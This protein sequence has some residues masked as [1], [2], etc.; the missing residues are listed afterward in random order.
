MG[1]GFECSMNHPAHHGPRGPQSLPFPLPL[2]ADTKTPRLTP[3]EGLVSPSPSESLHDASCFWVSR[4]PVSE[5]SL[6]AP[7]TCLG[8]ASPPLTPAWVHMGPADFTGPRRSPREDSVLP[9]VPRPVNATPPRPQ[10]KDHGAPLVP[11]FLSPQNPSQQPLNARAACSS[12]PLPNRSR[13]TRAVSLCW[14][15]PRAP[16]PSNGTNS[17]YFLAALTHTNLADLWGGVGGTLLTTDPCRTPG[18]PSG[19]SSS[20]HP[21]PRPRPVCGFR[22]HPL[23]VGSKW[24]LLLPGP[25][26]ELQPR[27]STR[28]VCLGD[29]QVQHLQNQTPFPASESTPTPI[30]PAPTLSPQVITPGH[31]VQ[32]WQLFP[33]HPW[34]LLQ[35]ILSALPLM[36]ILTRLLGPPLPAM[37]RPPWARV[38]AAAS[39]SAPAPPSP[40]RRLPPSSQQEP[41]KA[42][43]VPSPSSPPRG[44]AGEVAESGPTTSLS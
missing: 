37:S 25:L 6:A 14:E 44:A 7:H 16:Q 22:N 4:M 8:P 17:T 30:P 23:S 32:P 31:W 27:K 36:D 9:T 3:G 26:H 13:V 39:S 19:F 21:L 15:R 24:Y 20:A 34:W 18:Q 40:L 38:P 42:H 29:T 2:L 41:R 28:R 5:R 12:P 35:Q 11:Q 43:S 10:A 1:P 33:V